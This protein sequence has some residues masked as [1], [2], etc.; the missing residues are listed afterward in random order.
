MYNQLMITDASSKEEA[1]DPSNQKFDNLAEKLLRQFEATLTNN[2]PVRAI[3]A[4]LVSFF[5]FGFSRLLPIRY[6]ADDDWAI[7][8]MLNGNFPE[9][10]MS[11]FINALLSKIVSV[12]YAVLPQGW[13]CFMLLETC[14]A[15]GALALIL[16]YA[17]GHFGPNACL[18]LYVVFAMAGV[19]FCTY[20]LNFTVVA[21]FL[22]TV[23]FL[24]LAGQIAEGRSSIPMMLAGIFFIC[25][26]FMVRSNAFLL[27]IPFFVVALAYCLYRSDRKLKPRIRPIAALLVAC[28]LIVGLHVYDS[29]AW[30]SPEWAQWENYNEVRSQISDYPRKAYDDVKSEL[31]AIGISENDYWMLSNWSSGD[32]DVFDL[33]TLEKVVSIASERGTKS[34]IGNFSLSALI[35]FVVLA[36]G[37]ISSVAMLFAFIA[38]FAMTRRHKFAWIV[39]ALL[40]I[41]AFTIFGYFR[42]VGRLPERVA[43]CVVLYTFAAFALVCLAERFGTNPGRVNVSHSSFTVLVGVACIVACFMAVNARQIDI[44]PTTALFGITQESN[45]ELVTYMQDNPDTT[46]ILHVRAYSGYERV[47]QLSGMPSKDVQDAVFCAGGWTLESPQ[48][49]SALLER[50]GSPCALGALA[51]SPNT[52]LVTN[53]NYFADHAS[54]FLQEHYGVK[55]SFQKVDTIKDAPSET[56]YNVY[57]LK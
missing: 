33:E 47:Y 43:Y 31:S 18:V 49:R 7:C 21:C 46:F 41:M 50:T 9:G 19:P 3:V 28:G 24:V 25:A 20:A 12:L 51:K 39:M 6:G 27:S 54:V 1:K 45:S 29:A 32:T 16:Y 14:L 5:T 13:N 22:T 17:W 30:S 4:L 38:F 10:D 37:G 42:M 8:L 26:G 35:E 40:T 11:L 36:A 48:T 15:M 52:V 56:T 2:R 55:T 57:V 34:S 44:G 53:N 23:G